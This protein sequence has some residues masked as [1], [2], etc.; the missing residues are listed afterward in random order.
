MKEVPSSGYVQ[1]AGIP[2][3]YIGVE[4][5]VVGKVIDIRGDLENKP[6]LLCHVEEARG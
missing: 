6:S 4:G 3:V 5:D 1:T 2:G